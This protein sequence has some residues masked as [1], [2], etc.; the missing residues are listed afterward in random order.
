M[1]GEALLSGV[2]ALQ[3]EVNEA[4]NQVPIAK[5]KGAVNRN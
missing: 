2:E 3:A 5:K 4:E 1:I